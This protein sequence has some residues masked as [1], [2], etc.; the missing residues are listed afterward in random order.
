V[1]SFDGNFDKSLRYREWTPEGNAVVIEFKDGEVLRGSCLHRYDPGDERFYLIPDDPNSNNISVLVEASALAGVF[2]PQQYEARLAAEREE[3]KKA[4]A[5]ADLSQEETLGDFYFET[6]NYLGAMEQYEQAG[7]RFPQSGRLRRKMLATQ[8]NIGVQYV[9]RREFAEALVWMQKVL[10]ADPENA[11]AIKKV[12]QLRR[13]LER[14]SRTDA[15]EK[16][17]LDF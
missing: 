11:H 15:G 13:I 4:P 17:E 1:K 5:G 8:Y 12:A 2:S 6:R 7:R 10:K 14:G 3:K 16:Q 9:K